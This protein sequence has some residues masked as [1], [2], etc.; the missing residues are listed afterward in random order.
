MKQIAIIGGG[1]AGFFAALRL[2]ELRRDWRVTIIERGKEV[3]Q[4][5]KVSG[6]GRCNVTHACFE[7]REL[8]KH[9]PRG[10]RELLGAFHQFGPAQMVQWLETHGVRTKTEEDGRMFPVSNDSQTIIDCFLREA[11]RLGVEIRLGL[12]LDRI[13]PLAQGFD[14]HFKQEPTLHAD[15]VLLAAGSSP[16]IWDQLE[17]LGYSIVR[18]VPS[19]F[20]FNIPD[21]TLHALAGIT[22]ERVR[23]ES[24]ELPNVRT[25]GS[26]L[27]THWGLS[28]PAALR[29]SAWGARRWAELAYKMPLLLHSC[30]LY[31]PA[32]VREE[33]MELKQ[34]HPKRQV[35]SHTHFGLP[36]RWWQWLVE[37]SD[38]PAQTTW[39][40]LS[41]AQLAAL[42]QQLTAAPLRC[43]GKSTFKEEF[44]TAGGIDLKEVDFRTFQSKRHPGLF[45]AGEV[46]DIDAITGGFNFQAAWTGAW[47]AAEA[48]AG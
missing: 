37:R 15:A 1:A 40:N 34:A 38:I 2:A 47:L 30:P 27:I 25:E 36:I 19:L 13:E 26:M 43:E 48:M 21:K 41:K 5:V 3:L 20:T 4:K 46:L 11:K 23:L 18:P 32:E 9:Y 17:E 8:V 39:A 45:F 35:A 31:T 10:A 44:V 16:A 24:P 29:L 6:G 12:R 22:L 14:L 7:P 42:V 28:G 33:L